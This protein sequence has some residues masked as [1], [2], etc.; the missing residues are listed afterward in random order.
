MS[1]VAAYERQIR[2]RGQELQ[3]DGSPTTTLVASEPDRST[4]AASA[5]PG[6]EAPTNAPLAAVETI[7]PAATLRF[8]IVAPAVP[9]TATDVAA[10]AI[11]TDRHATSPPAPI[12]A[13]TL[14]EPAARAAVNPVEIDLQLDAI[15]RI[16]SET[17]GDERRLSA[18]P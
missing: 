12:A 15:N 14:S 4:V 6:S 7:L 3:N 16:T 5:T 10:M 8:P 13:P 11:H 9:K 17:A 1:L 18:D 2:G